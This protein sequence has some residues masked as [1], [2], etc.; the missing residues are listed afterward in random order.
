MGGPH[1]L[2]LPGFGIKP[3]GVD[4]KNENGSTIVDGTR[5]NNNLI[6]KLH[7]KVNTI[8]YSAAPAGDGHADYEYVSTGSNMYN[9]ATDFTT[10]FTNDP[11]KI[12]QTCVRIN[13]ADNGNGQNGDGLTWQALAESTKEAFN[14]ISVNSVLFKKYFSLESTNP[15]I[16]DFSDA[17]LNNLK[18][19]LNN[20]KEWNMYLNNLTIKN[21]GTTTLILRYKGS[22]AFEPFTVAF[23]A[24]VEGTENQNQKLI[25]LSMLN[26]MTGSPQGGSYR[27]SYWTQRNIMYFDQVPLDVSNVSSRESFNLVTKMTYGNEL[28]VNASAFTSLDWIP[29]KE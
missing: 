6:G 2:Q 7:N 5:N 12:D 24:T 16:F 20:G 4:T 21:S 22:N 14:N 8:S 19:N 23:N 1:F 9:S 15:D 29:V 28:H 26:P 25:W 27:G 3:E 18:T 10:D 17:A 11:D 13:N